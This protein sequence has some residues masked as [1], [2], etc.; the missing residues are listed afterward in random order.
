MSTREFDVQTRNTRQGSDSGRRS[1]GGG[2]LLWLGCCAS[3]LLSFQFK[4]GTGFLKPTFAF[5]DPAIVVATGLLMLTQPASKL[6]SRLPA[7]SVLIALSL[8]LSILANGSFSLYAVGQKLLGLGLLFGFAVLVAAIVSADEAKAGKLLGCFVGGVSLHAVIA[9]AAWVQQSGPSDGLL[10]ANPAYPRLSG[11][12]EDPNAFGGLV[13]SAFLVSLSLVRRTG[14]RRRLFLVSVMP[15]L[16][17][18]ILLTYSR[19]AWIGI[20]LGLLLLLFRSSWRQLMAGF[21]MLCAIGLTIFFLDPAI[22]EPDTGLVERQQSITDR[23]D[24]LE[25]GFRDLAHSPLFGIGVGESAVRYGVIP[26]NTFLWFLIESGPLGAA[27]FMVFVHSGLRPAL[28]RNSV[29]TSTELAA[30]VGF[31][32]MFGLSLGIEALYQRQ[33]WLFAGILSG[34]L[35]KE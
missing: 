12:I 26:H 17:V 1:A 27:A 24:G 35:P 32:A 33:W 3:F 23:I 31:A 9:I 19:S 25:A 29:L 20:A 10:L 2:S 18:S 6:L 8:L 11:L 14:G 16:V 34:L 21:L 7:A 15:I 28:K 4:A 13:G 30:A 5:S 22:L